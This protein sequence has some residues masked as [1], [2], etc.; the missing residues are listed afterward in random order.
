VSDS[1]L[2]T[3]QLKERRLGFLNPVARGVMKVTLQ[4]SAAGA[5]PTLRALDHS[6]PSGA[7]VGPASLGQVRGKPEL[8]DVYSTGSDPAVAARL[9]E[10][11]EEIL[12]APLPV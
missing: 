11:T 6:T 10:L 12:G 7:F 9:W 4:S 1:E 2:F 8:L 5:M 3:R